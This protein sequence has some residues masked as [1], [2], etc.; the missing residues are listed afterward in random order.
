MVGEFG[1]VGWGYGLVMARS[2]ISSSALLAPRISSTMFRLGYSRP[3]TGVV[4]SY[5][6]FSIAPDFFKGLGYVSPGILGQ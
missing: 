5:S 3:I 6:N 4:S 1:G 2:L